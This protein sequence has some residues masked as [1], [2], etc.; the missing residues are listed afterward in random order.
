MDNIKKSGRNTYDRYHHQNQ[1]LSLLHQR[2]FYNS[3][4]EGQNLLVW[5]IRFKM[6]FL[7]PKCQ[8]R[9]LKMSWWPSLLNPT[10]KKDKPFHHCYRIQ[11]HNALIQGKSRPNRFQENISIILPSSKSQN[12]KWIWS[13]KLMFPLLT[14]KNLKAISMYANEFLIYQSYFYKL[15]SSEA[16]LNS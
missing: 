8:F 12:I 3:S 11:S 9:S 7:Y 15:C 16:N 13:R 1:R 14:S 2:F 6:I 5:E 4:L 10:E